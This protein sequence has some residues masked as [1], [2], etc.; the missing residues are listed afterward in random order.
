MLSY[1]HSFHAGNYADVL[2]HIVLVEVLRYLC[3]KEKPFDYIDTHA[4]AGAYSLSSPYAT[5]TKEY[6]QGIGLLYYDKSPVLQPYLDIVRSFNS[7][8]RLE[9]YPGSP[10]F[11]EACLRSQDRGWLFDLHPAD[12]ELLKQAF[13]GNRHFRV[14]QENGFKE[15]I[16]R[17]P[18]VSR[19]ACVLIDPPYEV[20]SDYEQVVNTV[21]KAHRR[22]ATGTYCIWY[23]VVDRTRIDKME[24]GLIESGIRRIQLFELGQDDGKSNKGMYASG[25]IVINPPWTLMTKMQALLPYLADKLSPQ[26]PYRYRCVELVGEK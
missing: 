5:K 24:Q 13:S 18:P 3:E 6:E 12:Y 19:R 20:K 25:M 14:S 2:K 26:S 22:F 21:A 15:L 17:L 7:L 11:A 9:V 10:K 8:G 4:G 1:R 16:A 23:P